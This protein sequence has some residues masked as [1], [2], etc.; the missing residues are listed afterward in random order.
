MIYTHN[1]YYNIRHVN[2]YFFFKLKRDL[3][4]YLLKM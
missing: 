2:D 1:R 3:N 4:K